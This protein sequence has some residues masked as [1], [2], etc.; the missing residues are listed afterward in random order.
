MTK[1]S[2]F[3]SLPSFLILLLHRSL[4][5]LSIRLL[6]FLH[7][8]TIILLHFVS[9]H[10]PLYLC[11]NC[12]FPSPLLF[13]SYLLHILAFPFIPFFLLTFSPFLFTPSYFLYSVC[14][15]GLRNLWAK[16]TPSN[17]LRDSGN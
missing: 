2:F 15:C 6:P 7:V 14:S 17:P 13:Y 10:F 9:P 3:F 12:S 8:I 16:F 1:L 11:C 4:C 5:L